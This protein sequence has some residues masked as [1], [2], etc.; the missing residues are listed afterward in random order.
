MKVSD[1]SDGVR[2]FLIFMTFLEPK[3]FQKEGEKRR[4][5]YHF[6]VGKGRFSWQDAPKMSGF[7]GRF[8]LSVL[9]CGAS[10]DC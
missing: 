4:A 7:S 3:K 9:P 5:K 1:S 10:F 8:F 6:Y 2:K